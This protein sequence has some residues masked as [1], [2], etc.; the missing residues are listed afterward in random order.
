MPLPLYGSGG[1]TLRIR[2]AISPTA[3]LELPLT[4]IWV[5]A[6]TS[7]SMPSGALIGDRMRVADLKLDVAA[8]ERG[9]VADALD[10]ES[11]RVALGDAVDHV[12][13]QAAREAV[14]RAVL[15]AV[16]RPGDDQLGVL[17]LDGDVARLA[18][19]EIA[20]R[21]GYAHDL[22]LDRD[23]HARGHGDGL[24]SDSAHERAY[25]TYA[26]TSPPTP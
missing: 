25:Q 21:A 3:C 9:A 2:A 17:L 26:T 8:L 14:E 24:F 10:L 12:E 4:M 23:G 19:L 11:L 13:D 7:N 15:A 18:L 1:R 20:A 5:G 22:G 16:G 6:G